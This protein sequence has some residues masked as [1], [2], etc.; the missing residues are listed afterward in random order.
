MKQKL[1]LARLRLQI[2]KKVLERKGLEQKKRKELAAVELE[3]KESPVLSVGVHLAPKEGLTVLNQGNGAQLKEHVVDGGGITTADLSSDSAVPIAGQRM[4][5]QGQPATKQGNEEVI[6]NAPNAKK[7]A[8]AKLEQLRSRQKELKQKNDIA[9]L[10]NLIHRQR[11]MLQAQCQELTD[12]STQLQSCADSMKS[13]QLLFDEADHKV[14]EMN[15]RKRIVE[16]MVFRATE[17]LI[18][19]RKALS[20]KRNQN[21][22]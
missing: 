16:G 18:T 2:K 8:Q 21:L 1:H 3:S 15:R 10:R 5:G 20:E 13:K 6:D 12:S 14:E 7:Q 17:Q 9:N 4:S 19:A 11:D 22:R